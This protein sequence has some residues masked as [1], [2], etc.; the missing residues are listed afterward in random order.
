MPSSTFDFA[1]SIGSLTDLAE[2][3]AEAK[4]RAS[5][6]ANL[7]VQAKMLELL[8]GKG[9]VTQSELEA[10]LRG[11]DMKAGAFMATSPDLARELSQAV[12]D[13][14]SALG[15]IERSA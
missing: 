14:R 1:N 5:T 9:I 6:A 15:I 11:I 8:L 3:I 13:L 7:I 2:A 10:F 4:V 12:T